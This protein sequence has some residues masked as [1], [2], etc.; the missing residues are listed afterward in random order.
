VSLS[1]VSPDSYFVEF[2]DRAR[3]FFLTP[4]WHETLNKFSAQAMRAKSRAATPAPLSG[5]AAGPTAAPR[6]TTAF[7]S[8]RSPSPLP[9]QLGLFN[10]FVGGP[11][12][13]NPYPLPPP[14]NPYYGFT[15]FASNPYLAAVFAPPPPQP[16]VLNITH[17]YNQMQQP[18]KKSTLQNYNGLFSLLGGALKVAGAVLGH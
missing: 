6:M 4:A 18:E 3:T 13:Y 16:Q 14:V 17:V 11:P 8:P 2:E 5:S 7:N 1:L 10:P 9:P 15:P 12:L